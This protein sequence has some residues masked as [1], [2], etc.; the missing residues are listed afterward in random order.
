MGRQ[1]SKNVYSACKLHSSIESEPPIFG[2]S[3]LMNPMSRC[4]NSSLSKRSD[5]TSSR[6]N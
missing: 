6:R 5:A 3:P 1:A 2:N 4:G